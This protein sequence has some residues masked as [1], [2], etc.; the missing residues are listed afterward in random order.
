MQMLAN[1]YFII[2]T[3]NQVAAAMTYYMYLIDYGL[4]C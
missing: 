3:G 2:Q 4:N 1:Q